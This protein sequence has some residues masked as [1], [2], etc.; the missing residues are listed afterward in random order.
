[1]R[2][3]RRLLALLGILAGVVV[4]VDLLTKELV[5]D[6]LGDGRVVPVLGDV[7]SLRLV[8]NPGAAFSL[9]SGMTWVFTIIAVVVAVVVVRVSRRLGSRGWAVALG[10]L[11]GGAVG[12]LLDR[13]FRPPGFGRGHVIDFIDYGGL[14]VGNVAD[15]AI[16]VAAGLVMVLAIRGIAVDGTRESHGRA[17]DA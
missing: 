12:N 11:L 16:V 6:R 5:L 7:L 10:L 15:I 13:L 1:M 3:D 14:F 2:P 17:T 8:S 9:A 4:I